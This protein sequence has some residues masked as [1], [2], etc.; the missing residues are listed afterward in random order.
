M[1]FDGSNIWSAGSDSSRTV[2][3]L[4]ASDGSL[5]GTY[6]M[7]GFL[8]GIVF[9]GANIWV[10]NENMAT[11]S[12]LRASDGANL[13]SFPTQIAPWAIVFDGSNIW[14]GN[15]DSSSLSKM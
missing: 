4:R 9:D 11:V 15:A 13:G 7:S 14:V 1:T 3:K 6:P 2:T 5:L 12:E 8:G 10:T